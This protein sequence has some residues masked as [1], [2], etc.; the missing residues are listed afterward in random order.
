MNLM[1]LELPLIVGNTSLSDK[2][3]LK[4]QQEYATL[5]HMIK[6][7]SSKKHLNEFKARMKELEDMGLHIKQGKVYWK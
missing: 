6:K 3:K 7:P 5:S 2:E 1:T 4:L